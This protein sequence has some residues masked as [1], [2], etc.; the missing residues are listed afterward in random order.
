MHQE[1][2]I[3]K[4]P[5]WLWEK[6]RKSE[7]LKLFERQK[8]GHLRVLGKELP[9]FVV[10]VVSLKESMVVKYLKTPVVSKIP[11]AECTSQLQSLSYVQFVK[12]KKEKKEF[13]AKLN[14]CSVWKA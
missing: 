12:D 11:L 9:S 10:W 4:G 7:F 13:M 8:P 14:S 5:V 1:R 3:P 6:N 2:Y